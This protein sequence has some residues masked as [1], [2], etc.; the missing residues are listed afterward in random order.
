MSRFPK[1]SEVEGGQFTQVDFNRDTTLVQKKEFASLLTKKNRQAFLELTTQLTQPGQKSEKDGVQVEFLREKDSMDFSSRPRQYFKL[2]LEGQTFFVKKCPFV[3]SVGFGGGAQEILD[4][5]DAKK[6]LSNLIDTEIPDYQLGYEDAKDTYLFSKWDE[7]LK[8][9]LDDYLDNI[10]S[11][12]NPEP[13]QEIDRDWLVEKVKEINKVL[14]PHFSDLD[15][16]NLAYDLARKKIIV[17]DL[18]K[19]ANH[20]D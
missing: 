16:V 1:R 17:F 19:K 4:M 6:L 5:Q 13:S 20:A 7:A 10:D 18:I 15:S 9:N 8:V 2:Y 12:S 11:S 3:A 14:K